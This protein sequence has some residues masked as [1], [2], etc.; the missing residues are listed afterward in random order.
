[1]NNIVNYMT[2][3]FNIIEI[4]LR[5]SFN[6]IYN[7]NKKYKSFRIL[8]ILTL[9]MTADDQYLH[10]HMNIKNNQINGSNISGLIHRDF[11]FVGDSNCDFIDIDIRF[12]H[13]EPGKYNTILLILMN[14]FQYCDHQDLDKK[15]KNYEYDNDDVNI[16]ICNPDKDHH[17]NKNTHTSNNSG[18]YPIHDI[19]N[20]Y[21]NI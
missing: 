21:G 9:D 13:I 15:I 2:I 11:R 8:N 17:F 19:E 14:I 12:T 16:S 7:L 6:E 4:L 5:D 3:S 1:M 20:Q 18:N 10:V